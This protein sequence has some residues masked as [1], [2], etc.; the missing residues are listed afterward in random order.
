M[1]WAYYLARQKVHG[2]QT[3][4]GAQAVTENMPEQRAL[5]LGREFD[6]FN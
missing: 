2:E 4:L 1:P 5:P 6:P 3:V